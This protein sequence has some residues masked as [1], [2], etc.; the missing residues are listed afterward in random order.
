MGVRT[1]AYAIIVPGTAQAYFLILFQIFNIFQLKIN[2]FG[3]LEA[4]QYVEIA[5]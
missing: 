4:K 1:E 5:P 2:G 3:S